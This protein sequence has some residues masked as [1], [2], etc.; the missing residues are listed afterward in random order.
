LINSVQPPKTETKSKKIF[1]FFAAADELLLL[2]LIILS[3]T[4]H[5]KERKVSSLRT[6][7]I[8]SYC[9]DSPTPSLENPKE[10]QYDAS[11]SRP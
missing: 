9:L 1:R 10:R 8:L 2:L 6:I 11:N 4:T 7:R 5:K 3:R